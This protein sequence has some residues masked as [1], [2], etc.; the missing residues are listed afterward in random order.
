[1]QT[2]PPLSDNV[3]G[4]RDD[5]LRSVVAPGPELLLDQVLTTGI[6]MNVYAAVAAAV[7]DAVK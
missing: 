7:T 1:V 5:L 2:L 3:S 6:E 4:T